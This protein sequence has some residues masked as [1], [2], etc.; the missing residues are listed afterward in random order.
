MRACCA[1]QLEAVQ[2][3]STAA[4]RRAGVPQR[5]RGAGARAAGEQP[6]PAALEVS[7]A[8]GAVP[9]HGRRVRGAEGR[10]RP[11]RIGHSIVVTNSEGTR[12]RIMLYGPRMV[13][14]QTVR[15][16][17]VFFRKGGITTGQRGASGGLIGYLRHSEI[18]TLSAAP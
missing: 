6:A 5:I 13:L 1:T 9:E 16:G 12:L 4:L 17:E 10:T 15:N 14:L 11:A 7:D 18:V 2:Q 3:A 8:A